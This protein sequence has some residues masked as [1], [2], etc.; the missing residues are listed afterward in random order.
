MPSSLPTPRP[1]QRRAAPLLV[2]LAALAAVA[3]A[4]VGTDPGEPASVAFN[5]LPAPFI[6]VGDT[7]RD[8]EGN[9][10][11]LRESVRVF[12]ADQDVIADYPV[13]FLIANTAAKLTY[14]PATGIVAS[15]DTT[16]VRNAAI[17][18]TAGR[19]VPPPLQLAIVPVAPTRITGITRP[20]NDSIRLAFGTENRQAVTQFELQ[21]LLR[22][23]EDTARVSSY[24][25]EY[26]IVSAPASL[27][28][29]AFIATRDTVP[30]I[31]S[32][33]DTTDASGIAARYLRATIRAGA[34][35]DSTTLIVEARFRIRTGV[36]G[37][38]RFEVPVVIRRTAP[39][40]R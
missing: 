37:A 8:L 40:G 2:A 6:L 11:D 12:D 29:V 27:D 17:Q 16:S 35:D 23:A 20:Q 10:V 34:A 7:L 9:V 5:N 30:R 21:A 4:D 28:S 39:A 24:P 32:P 22:T 15:R 18:A 31:P 3:C 25:V 13:T 33:Y 19:L 14:D 36:G 26:R 1:P 38:L